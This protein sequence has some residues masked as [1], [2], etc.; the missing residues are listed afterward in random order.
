MLSYQY[1]F[2]VAVVGM[3]ERKMM[4]VV[5]FAWKFEVGRRWS[6]GDGR[7]VERARHFL[8][9][10]HP[11]SPDYQASNHLEK[12]VYHLNKFIRRL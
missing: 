2:M 9:G 3:C 11:L 5:E 8:V 6:V 12:R 10:G 7:L 1:A 4:V